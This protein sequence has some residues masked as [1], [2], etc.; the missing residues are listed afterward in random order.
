MPGYKAPVEDTI[1]LLSDV[2]DFESCAMLPGFS[3]APIDVASQIIAEAG[4]LCE[5]VLAPLNGIGDHAGCIRHP[6]SSVTTPPGFREAFSAYA[7]GGWIGLR[8]HQPL[9]G[10][11]CPMYFPCR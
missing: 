1:F 2:L 9:A 6:D 4:K 11:D 5:E 7:K 3:E 10:R 8:F